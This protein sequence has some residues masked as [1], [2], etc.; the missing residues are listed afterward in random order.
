M[1]QKM[2]KHLIRDELPPIVLY[3]IVCAS[4]HHGDDPGHSST[5]C[6]ADCAKALPE[7]IEVDGWWESCSA[8]WQLWPVNPDADPTFRPLA[9]IVPTKAVVS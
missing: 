8:G 9:H 6:V 4:V 1:S 5:V 2:T 3:A 7:T